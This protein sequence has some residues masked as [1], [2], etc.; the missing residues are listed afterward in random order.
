MKDKVSIVIPTYNQTYLK[1]TLDS[2]CEQDDNNFEVN[3]IENGKR[4]LKTPVLVDKYK[5]K[6]QINY[7]FEKIAGL[8]RARN[9]GVKLSKYDI[10]ALTDDDCILE[11]DWVSNIINFHKENPNVG[12]VGGK[13]SLI[14][15]GENPSWLIPPL[16]LYLAELDLGENVKELEEREYLVGANISFTKDM[17][18]SAN[19][20]DE[21]V[22]LVGKNFRGCDEFTFN[23]RLRKIGNPG[24]VYN[25]NVRV[26]HQISKSRMKIEYIEQR[27]YGQG[28]SESLL[29]KKNLTYLDQVKFLEDQLYSQEWNWEQLKI[30][31]SKLQDAE[32]QEF[33]INFLRC[34]ISYINGVKDT[35][36]S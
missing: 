15:L 23:E 5:K 35:L 11:R 9:I 4:N 29:N 16:S 19:G 25:P 33:K 20:F 8:N 17:F 7:I 36:I 1:D 3:I 14:F 34:R 21:N 27:A 26:K 2:I 31:E 32:F 24:L 6:I 10:I 12:V 18:T 28:V 30:A 13:V 22:G